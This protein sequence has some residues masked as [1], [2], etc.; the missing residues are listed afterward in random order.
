MLTLVDEGR[1]VMRG[2]VKMAIVLTWTVLVPAAHVPLTAL[3][4][5]GASGGSA[6]EALPKDVYPDSPRMCIRIPG[7]G[8]PP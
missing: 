8:F 6:E 7:T 2:I 1:L 3:S 4:E 5:Q